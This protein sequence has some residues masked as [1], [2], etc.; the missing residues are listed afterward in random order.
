MAEQDSESA[1]TTN[2]G[3]ASEAATKVEEA[4]ANVR[5][6]RSPRR[7]IVGDDA[8]SVARRYFDAITARDLET[9]VGMWANGG[10]E[11]V[12]GQ[13]DVLAPDGVREFIG[14]LFDAVPDLR[15]EVVST[16]T[17]GERCAVQW[18]LSGTFAGPGSL[19]G[20]E[21]T[22]DPVVM[23]GIDLLT[24]RDGMIQ[25]NDA[26]P[27]SIALPRQI[28]MMP[29]A[30]SRAEERLAGAFNAKTRV[31][32]RLS[33]GEAE[34]VAEGVWVV[35]GQPG[36]CNVYLV[37]DRGG[38]TLFDAGARTMVRSLARAGAKLGGIRRIVL[39][40]GH[41]DHRGAAPRLGVPVY[42]HPAEVEDAEGSGGFRYWG[43]LDG[44]PFPHR[45]IQK[46]IHRYAW[47]G[48][49]VTIA[50][51][52]V[53]GDE[54]AGFRVVEI[55]GHAP[56]QIALWRESDRLA[57]SSDC[58]YTLD[59]WGRDSEPRLPFPAYNYDTEQ[60]RASIVKLAEL[61]PAAAWP[62]HAKPLT[63][64]VRSQLLRATQTPA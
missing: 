1:G 16:T 17:Q 61:E 49:P 25:S 28:G 22:G 60:A 13:V 27:D 48:G 19:N 44:L 64:D 50:G 24:V 10:R 18:R 41:T 21:P 40:H 46:L 57:L 30:G 54:I 45:Q 62:G 5:Q 42:C 14:G 34:L 51:T 11:N 63:G 2:G 58:F 12:R 8:E 4:A 52:V 29:P 36:R 20:I 47:D 43:S 55:P 38:V 53:E 59:T 3:S 23:E 7:R 33:G 39:G 32:A 6:A 56:G 35:Q 31:G 26:F 37:E 15:F 9:A